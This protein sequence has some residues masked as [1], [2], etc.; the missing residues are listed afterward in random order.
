MNNK[1]IKIKYSEFIMEEWNNSLLPNIITAKK[2]HKTDPLLTK[3][4]EYLINSVQKHFV[5]NRPCS[6]LFGPILNVLNTK[7]YYTE[8][9]LKG[10]FQDEIEA[11]RKLHK[12][13]NMFYTRLRAEERKAEPV[14]E[15]EKNV[16]PRLKNMIYNNDPLELKE[17]TA[18]KN[19]EKINLNEK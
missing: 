5:Y 3:E 15:E 18:W 6:E 16:R 11:V 4:L 2:E 14:Q 9:G 1:E 19:D 7:E 12:E 13:I 8:R 10:A 17:Q